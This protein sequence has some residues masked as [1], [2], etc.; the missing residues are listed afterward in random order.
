MLSFL[1][2][3]K[4]TNPSSLYGH[5]SSTGKSE[6][7]FPSLKQPK[8]T[9]SFDEPRV[10]GE[11][12]TGTSIM[13]V[14]FNGGVVMGADSRTSTGDYVAN[15]A[16]DKLSIVHDKIYCCRSGSSAD[17]QAVAEIVQYYLDLH[18]I[19][20]NRPPTV[21]AAANI[22]Q[23][24]VYT[25]KDR[26]LAGIIVGGWDKRNGGSVYSIPL[27]GSMVKQ[28]YAI[29]GSGSTYIFAWCDSHFQLNMTKDQCQQF[30]ALGLS[31][32]MARDGSSGGLI[33]L[34][35]I[36]DKGVEKKFIAGDKLPFDTDKLI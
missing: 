1:E 19:E 20:T 24:I 25:N 26:L 22:F 35:T 15:R 5:N 36:D 16:T 2:E 9:S 30:V 33:R 31:H 12:M 18:S 17:T 8:T 32:A 6:S 27:G 29:G 23:D 7:L 34:V 28:P 4:I 14:A 3:K 11:S 13:A 10:T 21:Q